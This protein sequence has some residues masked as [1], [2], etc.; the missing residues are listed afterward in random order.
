MRGQS[1]SAVPARL[2]GLCPAPRHGLLRPKSDVQ[3]QMLTQGKRL[4]VKLHTKLNTSTSAARDGG[5]LSFFPSARGL[6]CC[7]G[8]TRQH[9]GSAL[10]KQRT[11]LSTDTSSFP[12]TAAP[13]LWA[14]GTVGQGASPALWRAGGSV[15]ELLGMG[16]ARGALWAASPP[17]AAA[18]PQSPEQPRSAA[19]SSPGLRYL[20][21]LEL[22]VEGEEDVQGREAALVHG[23]V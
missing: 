14:R 10:V 9:Q 11:R 19:S 17:P 6:K 2:G 12:A 13:A 8:R 22:R 15:C 1:S 5:V 18:A 23:D 16:A 7:G 3:Q 4:N 20:R 21:V